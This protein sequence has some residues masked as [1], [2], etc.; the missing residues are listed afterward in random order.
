SLPGLDI[1]RE[2]PADP[3]TA[4]LK[5]RRAKHLALEH[6]GDRGPAETRSAEPRRSAMELA[7]TLARDLDEPTG[8]PSEGHRDAARAQAIGLGLPDLGPGAPR[9]EGARVFKEELGDLP[10]DPEVG[11]P[12]PKLDR[13]I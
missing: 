2:R 11:R 4:P 13:G 10:Y 5:Q 6:L 1:A 8:I 9:P 7:R 12:W 3:V